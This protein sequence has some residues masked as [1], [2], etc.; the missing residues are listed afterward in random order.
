MQGLSLEHLGLTKMDIGLT[1]IF[2]Y[3]ILFHKGR[4]HR[5]CFVCVWG[6]GITFSGKVRALW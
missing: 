4:S 3:V 1:L 2:N 6:G 5:P